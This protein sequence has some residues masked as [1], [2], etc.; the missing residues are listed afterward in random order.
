MTYR[1][2]ENDHTLGFLSC[3]CDE[4]AG[5]TGSERMAQ[6]LSCGGSNFNLN[7]ALREITLGYGL[8]YSGFVPLFA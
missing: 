3:I 1:D 5:R 6:A 4:C 8:Q 2:P 7:K